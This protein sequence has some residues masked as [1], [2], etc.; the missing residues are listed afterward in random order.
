MN[1]HREKRI[2]M[3]GLGLMGT[4]LTERLLEHGFHVLVWNRTRDKATPL[5][6]LGAEWSDNP[7]A[8]CDRAIVSLYTS[9]VVDCVLQ[10]MLDEPAARQQTDMWRGK[11][12]ID[13]T[14]GA[15]DQSAAI[16]A[17]LAAW[18]IH[19]LDAPISGSSEQTRRGEA[20]VMVGGEHEVFEICN[21]LWPLLG[22]NVYHVGACGSASKMKLVSNLV[23]G[24]NRAALAEALV[25]ARGIG[26]DPAAAL[27]VLRG[28]MAYSRVMDVKGQ[29]MLEQDFTVQARLSQHLKDVRLILDSGVALPLSE[30]HRQLLEQ[31]E[32]MGLG[33]VDN[34]AIIKAVE[35]CQQ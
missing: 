23:L 19:Y 14:T 27:E 10:Q 18:G 1:D 15:P 24:L 32:R 29:K 35:A 2:G 13:T 11:I 9:D 33:E 16:G 3:I 26:V 5:L 4:A 21:E 6:A 22:A 25:F 7:L 12:V 20:T 8:D 17:R 28:S 31:A 34:C 30:T